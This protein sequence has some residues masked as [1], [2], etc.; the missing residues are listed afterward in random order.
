M[1]ELNIMT[2]EVLASGGGG[3]NAYNGSSLE[4]LTLVLVG[5][6]FLVVLVRGVARHRIGRVV[7]LSDVLLPLTLVGSFVLGRA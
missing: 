4:I 6:S 7:E 5:I 1:S 2:S 3:M